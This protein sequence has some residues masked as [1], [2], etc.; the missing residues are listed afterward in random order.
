MDFHSGTP[1]SRQ[2]VEQVLDVLSRGDLGA[3]D[4][5]PSVR[6]F[7]ADALVNPNTVGRAYRELLI[8]GITEGRNGSGVYV[9]ASGPDIARHLR[10]AGTLAGFRSAARAALSAGHDRGGLVRAL[11]EL[12]P[13]SPNGSARVK[14]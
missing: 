6:S 14:P 11:R 1:P 12:S 9:T 13:T 8:L 4:R 5:L 3:G 2:L 7:A 10:L